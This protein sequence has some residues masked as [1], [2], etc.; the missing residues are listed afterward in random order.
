MTEQ[1]WKAVRRRRWGLRS[2]LVLTMLAALASGCADSPERTGSAAAGGASQA[3]GVAG[4]KWKVT[5]PEPFIGLAPR[6][7]GSALATTRTSVLA[8]DPT[9][10]KTVLFEDKDGAAHPYVQ[11]GVE[12]FLVRTSKGAV[13]HDASGA[14][15]SSLALG[16][17][18]WARLV[19][20]GLGTF[21][22]H[23][24]SADAEDSAVDKGRIFSDTGALSAT[25]S[26]EGLVQSRTTKSYVIWS[27]RKA[28][29]KSKLNGTAVWSASV[30]VHRFETDAAGRFLVV[31]RAGDTRVVEL[32]DEAKPIGSSTF[33]T[34]IWNVAIS[35][36]GVYAAACSK[37]VARLF[38]GGKLQAS[39]PLVGVYPVSLDVS[40]RGQVL[41]GTQDRQK[42]QT[43]VTLADPSGATVWNQIFDDDTNAYRPDV[44]FAPDGRGFF[45]REKSGLSFYAM[46]G[47]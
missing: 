46:E 5:S 34:P 45:V 33:D 1:R 8:I 35:P 38:K 32:Y 10:T 28:L 23:A 7:D 9:G 47:T 22:P 44:R 30:A 43:A 18:E 27:T 31:H 19:P 24:V 37:T 4:L 21:A 12:G 13:V 26:A 11:E 3:L 16:P 2:V 6:S 29:V 42:K 36:S 17:N 15:K 14:K 20:G 40:D 39:I 25:F 41:V